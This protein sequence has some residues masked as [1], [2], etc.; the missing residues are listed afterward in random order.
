MALDNRQ[1]FQRLDEK[2][3]LIAQ[4]YSLMVQQRDEALG[5]VKQMQAEIEKRDA[6]ISRLKTEI[7]NL[8]IVKTAFPSAKAI[9]DSRKYL[10]GL[11]RE[12]DQCI[13]DLT[14]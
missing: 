13:K 14:S 5:A 12:I 1:A 8:V 9:A 2:A 3:R 11:A 7:E 10:S 6:E 4:K